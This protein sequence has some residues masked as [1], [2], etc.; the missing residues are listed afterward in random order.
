MK[1][2]MLNSNQIRCTLT[3]SDL[4][5][6]GIDLKELVYGSQKAKQLYREMLRSAATQFGFDTENM[7]LMIEAIPVSKDD[8]VLLVTKV[9]YP[10]ELDARFSS[11]SDS[12]EEDEDDD[13]L[14]VFPDDE[15]EVMI[16]E[17]AVGGADD[18]L[19][20]I[21]SMHDEEDDA[22]PDADFTEEI[23]RIFTFDNIDEVIG[24]ARIVAGQYSAENDLYRAYDGHYYLLLYMG[25][26]SPETFNR[27]CNILSEYGRLHEL[28]AGTDGFIRDH[29]KPVV[30]KNAVGKLASLNIGKPAALNS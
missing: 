27:V 1:I 16:P 21:D 6:R 10:D 13:E 18:I 19:K 25:S 3:H 2:E 17:P 22:D 23:L 24:A 26:T 20:I 4:E 8:L 15:S 5:K 30:L 12:D 28:Y 9:Q 7:P 14:S 29:Y 11:F